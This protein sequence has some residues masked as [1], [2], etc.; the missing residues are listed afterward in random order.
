[1]LTLFVLS[2]DLDGLSHPCVKRT[3]HRDHY[4]DARKEIFHSL[5]V[6]TLSGILDA[7]RYGKVRQHLVIDTAEANEKP[8]SREQVHDGDHEAGVRP[9][10]YRMGQ[11]LPTEQRA[12]GEYRTLV[13]RRTDPKHKFE[14]PAEKFR[15]ENIKERQNGCLRS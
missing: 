7:T 6:R 15:N 1:M 12:P 4:Q 2:S 10:F 8:L 5:A 3:T 9:R 13:R 14:M 11:S